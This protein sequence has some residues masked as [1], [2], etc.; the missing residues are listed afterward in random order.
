MRARVA[1]IPAAGAALVVLAV[2]P[3]L[4]WVP[5]REMEPSLLAGD[6]VVI[7]PVEPH[8][9]DLVAVVDP[10][11]PS[12][13]T[14]RRVET[15]GGAIRYADGEFHTANLDEPAIK[16]MGRDTESVVLR[17]DGHLTRVS[18]RAVR[19]ELEEVGVPDDRIFLSA[20][21]RDEAMDSRWWGPAP[22]DSVQGVVVAR[23]G[24]AHTW[25]PWFEL[26]FT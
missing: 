11:D 3:R 25:R 15:I 6:L 22:I 2:L 1:L 24:P 14:L 21:A 5:D 13:W 17:E 4:A 19:W 16:E 12:R 18:P 20:D 8:V 26:F 23:V 9:G 10:L 7:L